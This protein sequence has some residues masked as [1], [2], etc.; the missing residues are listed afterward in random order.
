MTYTLTFTCPKCG[1][2]SQTTQ[3]HSWP[4]PELK[5]GDC[6]MTDVEVVA[7]KCVGVDRII[8]EKTEGGDA[9]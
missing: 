4:L 1:K 5:C 2:H 6:L 8:G 7:M 3:L 9:A